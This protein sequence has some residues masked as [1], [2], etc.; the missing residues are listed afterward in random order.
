MF[1]KI[2]I[3]VHRDFDMVTQMFPDLKLHVKGCQREQ[4]EKYKMA[5]VDAAAI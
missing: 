3:L 2:L 5:Q 4:R 1:C